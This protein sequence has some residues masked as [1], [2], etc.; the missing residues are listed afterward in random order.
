MGGGGVAEGQE[1]NFLSQNVDKRVKFGGG[2]LMVWGVISWHGVGRLHCIDGH[3]NAELYC[4]ILEE[5][6]LGSLA[7]KSVAQDDFIFQRD[8]D[9]KHASHH[10]KFWYQ[11]QGINVLLWAPSLPDMNIIEHV[12]NLLDQRVQSRNQLPRNLGE[13]WIAL[14]EEWYSIEVSYIQKLFTSMPRRIVA[15]QDANGSYTKY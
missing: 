12:W 8:N 1:R 11:A 15:L 5:S 10:A 6:L 7:D 9:P 13:L 3:M 2:S 14:E 4:V